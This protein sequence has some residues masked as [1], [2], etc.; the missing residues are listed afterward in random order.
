MILEGRKVIYSWK[1]V[2]PNA[3]KN[4]DM[5]H[6]SKSFVDNETQRYIEI[7]LLNTGI[8]E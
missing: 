7:Q 6:L 3:S 2:K 5:R 8:E 4:E 1:D